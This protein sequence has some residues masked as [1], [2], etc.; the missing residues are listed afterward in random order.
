MIFSHCRWFVVV[1]VTDLEIKKILCCCHHLQQVR[2]P[3]QCGA[4]PLPRSRFV[5]YC[6]AYGAENSFQSCFFKSHGSQQNKHVVLKLKNIYNNHESLFNSS[7]KIWYKGF[8]LFN[9]CFFKKFPFKHFMFLHRI[10]T[11]T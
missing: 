6:A 3:Y 11:T 7:K 2:M 1:V 5:I 4:P 9:T 10:L 8:Y